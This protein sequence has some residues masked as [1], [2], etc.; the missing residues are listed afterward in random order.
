MIVCSFGAH[1]PLCG[2]RW[3]SDHRFLYENIHVVF[4]PRPI[5][6][7]F[8]LLGRRPL[9]EGT[10]VRGMLNP[11]KTLESLGGWRYAN[12]PRKS[13]SLVEARVE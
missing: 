8:I 10:R 5:Q 13:E 1:I 11:F 2:P 9:F 3:T 4:V 6:R 12:P 7:D